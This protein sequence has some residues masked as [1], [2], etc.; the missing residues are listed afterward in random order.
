LFRAVFGGEAD[1]QPDAV[2][3]LAHRLRKRLA[4]T[5]TSVL[6]MRGVG[7]LLVDELASDA[8]VSA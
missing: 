2:D 1:H 8:Q 5:G 4:G 3:V 6:T 7:Y